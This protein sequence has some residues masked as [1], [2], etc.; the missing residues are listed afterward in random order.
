MFG[1]GRMPDIADELG[2]RRSKGSVESASIGESV[3]S[4]SQCSL[5]GAGAGPIIACTVSR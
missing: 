4:V 5:G 1:W 3:K 2:G